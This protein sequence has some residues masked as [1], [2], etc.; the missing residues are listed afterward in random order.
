MTECLLFIYERLLAL[1]FLILINF[2]HQIIEC[3]KKKAPKLK[4][5]EKREREWALHL[6]NQDQIREFCSTL[7]VKMY[8]ATDNPYIFLNLVFFAMRNSDPT[9]TSSCIGTINTL[10]SEISAIIHFIIHNILHQFI[11]LQ[12]IVI[13]YG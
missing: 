2:Q 9:M 7:D 11:F 10:V 8:W 5:K 1:F 6:A 12:S 13:Y 4:N 3:L